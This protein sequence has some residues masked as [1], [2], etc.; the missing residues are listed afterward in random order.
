[1]NIRAAAGLS[2]LCASL[3]LAFTASSAQALKGTTAF[4]CGVLTEGASFT[5][6][7]CTNS[8]AGKFGHL[9]LLNGT[10]TSVEVTNAK[11][12]GETSKSTNAVLKGTVAGVAV[13]ITCTKVSSGAFTRVENREVAEGMQA[14][15][16]ANLSYSGCT[17]TVKK[18]TIKEPI[19]AEASG[20]TKVNVFEEM[21]IEITGKEIGS[22]FGKITFE[23]AECALKGISVSVSGAAIGTP[24]GA[25]LNF[26][27][28]EAKSTLK[29]G[30]NAATFSSSVT[31]QM[32]LAGDPITVTT[33]PF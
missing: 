7:H 14:V 22:T 16:E 2:L 29:L 19:T 17:T 4:A 11:T 13:E 25:T 24:T 3:F 15:G 30:G 23:G 10:S 8:G 28:G 18:C 21:W 27:S 26:T 20:I 32:T 33:Q 5:D 6:A 9:V 12:A 31:V 1:M